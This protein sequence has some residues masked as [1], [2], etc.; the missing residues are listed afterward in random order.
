MSESPQANPYAPNAGNGRQVRV[1]FN[2]SNVTTLYANA[3]RTSVGSAE[4]F[5]DLG[6]NHVVP[7]ARTADGEQVGENLLRFDVSHRAVMTFATAKQLA[8]HLTRLVEQVEQQARQNTP[9]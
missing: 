5:L 2:E 9:K 4:V 7:P 3:F 8:Q 1:Q 6:I